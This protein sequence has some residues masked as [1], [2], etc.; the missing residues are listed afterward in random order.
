MLKTI[1]SYLSISV[2]FTLILCF[3][4]TTIKAANPEQVKVV[5]VTVNTENKVTVPELGRN[6]F[7][8]SEEGT[9]Q[10]ILSVLPA[11]STTAPIN[12]AIVIQ[13]GSN[14][15]N[16]E[17]GAIKEFI[18]TLPIGSQ[19]MVTYLRGN[20]VQTAQ[21]F[22]TNLSEAGNA[23]HVVSDSSSSS[24]SPYVTLIDVMK[25]F[26]GMEKGRNQ[27]LFISN[28]VDNL[29]LGGLSPKSNIYLERAI[30]I[31]QQENINIYSLFSGASYRGT[32]TGQN[33]LSYLSEETGGHAFIAGIGGFVSF[34]SPL[35]QYRQILD[36]Q[37]VITYK[38][39]NDDKGFRH[40]KVTTD[41]SNIKVTAP[42]GYVSKL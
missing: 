4:F 30:K 8:V 7:L 35:K 27:I 2:L 21:P 28:G 23:L 5:T 41:F 19:V 11:N 24:S 29:N 33:N 1:K 40:V 36:N 34:D 22:T 25:Q 31:A 3:S 9:K 20:F 15:V 32:F 17:L 14:Q 18:N 16:S 10:E 37:Y 26:N 38:S 12:L 42:K 13:E 39:S 6:D